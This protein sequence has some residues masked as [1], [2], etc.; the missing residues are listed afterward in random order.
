[1]TVLGGLSFAAMAGEAAAAPLG[2]EADVA[3][4]SPTPS[5]AQSA[6]NSLAGARPLQ[7]AAR[8]AKSAAILGGQP[9][10]LDEQIL[11]GLDA[12]M[13]NEQPKPGH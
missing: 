3:A 11:V 9:S 5:C 8:T 10:A 2:A 13:R 4:L 7:P 12:E 6:A 1:M